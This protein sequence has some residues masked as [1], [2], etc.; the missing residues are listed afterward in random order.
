VVLYDSADYWRGRGVGEGFGLSPLEALACVR[1]V[2]GSHNHALADNLDPGLIGHQIGYGTLVSDL[3]RITAAVQ[4]PGRWRPD[5]VA[6]QALDRGLLGR[7]FAPA[8]EPGPCRH[9]EPLGPSAGGPLAPPDQ[10]DPPLLPALVLAAR[11]AAALAGQ[12]VIPGSVPN[13]LPLN[14]VPSRF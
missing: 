13:S 1:V 10:S 6:L 2:F 12:A 11:S 14:W 8:L 7:T 5:T 3:E 4:N 9:P